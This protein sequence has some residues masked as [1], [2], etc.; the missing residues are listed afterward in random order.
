MEYERMSR[1][2]HSRTNESKPQSVSTKLQGQINNSDGGAV[3][4]VSQNQLVRRFLILGSEGRSYYASQADK[5]DLAVDAVESIVKNDPYAALAT[6]KDVAETHAAAKKTPSILLLAHLVSHADLNV[7]KAAY[8]LLPVVLETPTMFYDFME[9]IKHSGTHVG[10]NAKTG[11]QEQKSGMRGM[12]TG[13]MNALRAWWNDRDNNTLSYWVRKYKGRNDWK[14]RDVL[15]LLHINPSDKVQEALLGFS[16]KNK[17][18]DNLDPEVVKDTAVQRVLYYEMAQVADDANQVINCIKLAKL[19][20]EMIPS[21]WH[22]DPRVWFALVVDMPYAALVRSL[23]RTSALNLTKPLS[24]GE[25]IIVAKLTDAELIKRSK[26]HPVALLNALMVYKQGHGDKGSLSWVVNQQIVAALETAFYTAFGNVEPTGKRI[27]VA[28]DVS[29]SMSSANI[30]GLKLSARDASLAMVLVTTRVEPS[31]FVGGFS[32]NFIP[33]AINKNTN[34]DDGIRLIN[35]LPFDATNLGSAVNYAIK[36][37]IEVDTFIVYTDNEVNCGEN[38]KTA[39]NRYRKQVNPDAK[40]I[41]V[42]MALNNFTCADPNDPNM[43]D[44]VGFD[45]TAPQI[46]SEFINGNL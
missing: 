8:A 26:I 23:G 33:L 16:V 10:R 11:K 42:G 24:S 34:L 46:M 4:A 39:I 20:H 22:N 14:L 27:F 28:L 31:T 38:P 2:L 15:R 12:G 43:L 41:M 30:N 45:A 9:F 32:S 7:R 25:K 44:V 29:G 19:T 1:Y 5:L 37:G 3:Y 35:R 40:V 21:K 18:S 6:L 36:H 13:F 17:L